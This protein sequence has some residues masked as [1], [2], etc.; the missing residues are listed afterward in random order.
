MGCL[1]VLACEDLRADISKN[2]IFKKE[3]QITGLHFQILTIFQKEYKLF[4]LATLFPGAGE[5]SRLVDVHVVS[6]HL[7]CHDHDHLDGDA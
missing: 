1:F 2:K 4:H 6:I 3:I 5:V 7:P